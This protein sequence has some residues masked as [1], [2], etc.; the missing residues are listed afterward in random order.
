MKPDDVIKYLDSLAKFIQESQQ[1]MQVLVSGAMAGKMTGRIFNNQEG[2]ENTLGE[3]LG[4][5]SLEYKKQKIRKYP[6]DGSQSH[7]NLFATRTLFGST[8]QVNDKGNVY[9]AVT[10]VK[11]LNVPPKTKKR[12]DGTTYTTKGSKGTDTIKVAEYLEKQ[13]GEIF[14]PT[15]TETE[16]AV[17]IGKKFIYKRVEQFTSK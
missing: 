4:T 8:R 2:S 10:D 13:Y 5:Y 17:E 11:Y 12:K 14:A 7:V 1:E 6:N 3:S 15:E 9:V 16:K